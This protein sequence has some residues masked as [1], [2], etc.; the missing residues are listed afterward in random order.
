MKIVNLHGKIA[1]KFGA[2]WELEI[3]SISE[4]LRAIDAN[5]GNFFEYLSEKQEENKTFSFILADCSEKIE[6]IDELF[7]PLP[8]KC[9]EFHVIPNAEGGMAELAVPLL[10]SLTTSMIMRSLF[11]PPKPEEEKQSKSFLFQGAENVTQQ[12]VAVPL[13]Y[14]RLLVG[15][16]VVSTTMRH[17]DRETVDISVAESTD[18]RQHVTYNK[19]P[20]NLSRFNSQNDSNLSLERVDPKG[21]FSLG[22]GGDD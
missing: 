12:G 16:V 10:I 13:G 2:R 15:S 20:K 21:V 18:G 7:V 19:W 17:V 6:T 8:K 14:G 1:E 3:N 5:V 22:G 9:Q 4:A 11:K